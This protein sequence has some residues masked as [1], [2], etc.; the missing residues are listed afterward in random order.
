MGTGLAGAR[1]YLWIA[2]ITMALAAQAMPGAA[3][4]GSLP[5]PDSQGDYS[6][7]LTHL[8]W[9]VVDPDPEGL[10]MRLS[11]DFPP[12]QNLSDQ[13]V[14][15]WN[16]ADWPVVRRARRGMILL[17]DNNSERLVSVQ[18]DR[19]LPWLKV[20]TGPRSR[21]ALVRAN[22]RFVRPAPLRGEL[23]FIVDPDGY[24][25]V[26]VAPSTGAEAVTRVLKDEPFLVLQ[27]RGEWCLVVAPDGKRG[28]MP[29]GHVRVERKDLR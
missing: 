6:G 14:V 17:A 25:K 13:G 9:E 24:T 26:R 5:R 22:V 11:K 1:T 21:I 3:Q 23:A 19:G 20:V 12:D 8:V 18:D 15:R 29:A 16:I 4:E 28:F 10:N 2:L 27:T 7:R